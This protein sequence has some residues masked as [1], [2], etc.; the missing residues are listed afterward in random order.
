MSETPAEEESPWFSHLKESDLIDS[1]GKFSVP[2][3]NMNSAAVKDLRDECESKLKETWRL[4]ATPPGGADSSPGRLRQDMTAQREKYQPICR[5][6]KKL[7]RRFDQLSQVLE[8]VAEDEII[9][10]K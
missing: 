7:L 8:T 2:A 5:W 3:E 10:Q 1:Y 6:L 9:S 4:L